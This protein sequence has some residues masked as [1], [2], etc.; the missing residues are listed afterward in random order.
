MT[1]FILFFIFL[2]LMTRVVNTFCGEYLE[3]AVIDY[4]EQK[5]K[6]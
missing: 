3:D 5:S 1:D 2:M 6:L 4:M